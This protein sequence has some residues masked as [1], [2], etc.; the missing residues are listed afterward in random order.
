MSY[1]ILF[2]LFRL[3]EMLKSNYH[4]TNRIPCSAYC[5][6]RRIAAVAVAWLRFGLRNAVVV[7]VVVVVEQAFDWLVEFD[8]SNCEA[9][10]RISGCTA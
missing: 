5:P 9:W 10:S 1:V 8:W 7:V 2:T 4:P 3:I 6:G